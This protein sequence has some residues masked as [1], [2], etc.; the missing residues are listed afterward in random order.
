MLETVRTE[1]SG[2]TA[3]DPVQSALRDD[4]LAFLDAHPD[5]LWRECDAGH[6][7]AGALVVDPDSGR[8]LLHLHKRVGRW[9]QF[10]GHLEPGDSSLRDTAARETAEESGLDGLVLLDSP[11]RLDRHPAPCRPAPGRDHLDVQYVALAPGGAVPRASDESLGLAWFDW[12]D[13][14]REDTSVTAL[15][16]AARTALRAP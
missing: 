6:L 9:L 3:P 4:Y 11:V 7:T 1:L 10:G 8:V 16:A 15:V 13:V 14:P 5:G 12:D 2:W